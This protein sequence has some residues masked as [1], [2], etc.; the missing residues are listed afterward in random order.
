[1][2]NETVKNQILWIKAFVNG[3]LVWII[4]YIIY[5]IP[6][7]MVGFKMGFELG[8]N[9]DD[10]SA[11][12]KQISETISQMYQANHWYIIGFIIITALL[13]FWRAKK[14]SKSTGG[15]TIVNGIL[16]A[17][18]PVLFTLLFIFLIGYNVISLI[19]IFVFAGAGYMG[20]YLNKSA[21]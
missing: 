11:L 19:G 14:V 15:K 2:E 21:A 1:M 8:P 9:A 6:G 3:I 7:L 18:F 4:G 17:S 16:V 12:S 20:G 13:I 5:L 10:P